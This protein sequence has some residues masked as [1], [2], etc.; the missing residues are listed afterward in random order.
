MRVCTG[1]GKFA[2]VEGLK[3]IVGPTKSLSEL[4]AA[5]AEIVDQA[6]KEEAL[7]AI[8]IFKTAQMLKASA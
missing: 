1:S 5:A 7:I 8:D 6:T 2:I 4:E 3:A